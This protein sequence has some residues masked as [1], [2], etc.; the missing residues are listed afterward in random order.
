MSRQQQEPIEVLRALWSATGQ[1][2]ADLA[3]AFGA[4]KS[5]KRMQDVGFEGL[6][7]PDHADRDGNLRAAWRETLRRDGKLDPDAASVRDLV[8]GPADGSR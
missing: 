4:E 5:C 6:A 2:A 7:D 1:S 8:L 3:E